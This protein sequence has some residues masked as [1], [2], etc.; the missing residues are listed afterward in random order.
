MRDP[1]LYDDA[2]V[3]KNKLGIKNQEIL[4]S[5]EADYVVYRLKEIALNKLPGDYHTEHFF[6]MHEYIFQDLFDWAGQSRN[7]AIY[8]EEDV[9]GGQSIEYSDPFDIV[10]DVRHVLSDMRNK[11]W[12]SMGTKEA[13][14]EFSDSLAKLWKIHPFREGNTRT[15]VTFCCQF[16]DEHVFIINREL[17]EKN[18]RYVRTSLVAYNAYFSDG[19]NFS[20]KEYLE[21]I[22]FDSLSS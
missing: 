11:E 7:I 22:V 5:A 13:A 14:K 6:R 19:S 1:Y 4:D 21:K 8:K 17:F 2:P 15:T 9:L 16:I 18:A 20:K 3:L 10:T 12:K